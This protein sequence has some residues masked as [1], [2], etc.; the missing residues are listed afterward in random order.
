[1]AQKIP[2]LWICQSSFQ[3][4]FIRSKPVNFRFFVI[5]SST[6]DLYPSP[7]GVSWQQ[8]NNNTLFLEDRAQIL[9]E[10]R[11][12]FPV[13]SLISTTAI[14]SPWHRIIDWKGA[15]R[16]PAG[17]LSM[18]NLA[19]GGPVCAWWLSLMVCL[20]SLGGD[21]NSSRWLYQSMECIFYYFF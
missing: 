4:P 19:V 5:S 10:Y 11:N 21:E 20:P 8:N 17:G 16:W 1:M 6:H 15:N 3:T 9:Q 7:E 14:W 2:H 12:C 13:S 18:R